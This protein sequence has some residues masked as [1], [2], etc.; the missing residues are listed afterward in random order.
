MESLHKQANKCNPLLIFFF[1]RSGCLLVM[2]SYMEFTGA[3]SGV[4][5]LEYYLSFPVNWS[6]SELFFFVYPGLNLNFS[7]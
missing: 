3:W 5:F 1:I 2:H 7:L 4:L 6:F